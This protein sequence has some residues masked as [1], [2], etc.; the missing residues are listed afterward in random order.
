MFGKRANQRTRN[1]KKLHRFTRIYWLNRVHGWQVFAAVYN[2]STSHT[3][4]TARS[5]CPSRY[6]PL[7]SRCCS[8]HQ[9]PT[10]SLL[11]LASSTSGEAAFSGA[12]AAPI[13]TP[14]RFAGV[15][16]SLHDGEDNGV[17]VARARFLR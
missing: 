10:S 1:F 16:S 11:S 5:N 9:A 3:A 17:V 6:V 15:P 2:P 12:P 14:L 8:R 4:H 13:P 7:E